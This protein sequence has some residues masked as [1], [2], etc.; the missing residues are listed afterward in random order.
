M[1]NSP[2]AETPVKRRQICF[3]IDRPVEVAE[4]DR[5]RV[6]IQNLPQESM[7]NWKVE[8]ISREVRLP[9]RGS[10]ALF[11]HSTFQGMLISAEDLRRTRPAFVPTLS[12][13][14]EARRSVL[15]L[16]DGRRDL[17]E[18]ELEVWRRHPALFRS[19]DEA[20]AFVAEVVTR[21]AE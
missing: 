15:A 20:A 21:Y 5:I 14:G 19:A 7:V 17:S 3:P 1:T 12:A 9:A 16:C 2:L 18:I 11:A 8:I 13:A 6:A 4:G 10:V